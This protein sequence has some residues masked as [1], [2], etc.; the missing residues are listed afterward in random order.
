[1]NWNMMEFL[2]AYRETEGWEPGHER[3]MVRYQSCSLDIVSDNTNVPTCSIVNH[4]HCITT[5]VQITRGF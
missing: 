2:W 4:N 3:C 5:T 1:M